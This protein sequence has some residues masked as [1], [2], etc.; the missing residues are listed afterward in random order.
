MPDTIWVT[1]CSNWYMSKNG[2][3]S[4]WPYSGARFR[5]ELREP[6]LAEFEIT[7]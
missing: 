4:A 3:P 6:D 5:K 2:V 1:G 7:T